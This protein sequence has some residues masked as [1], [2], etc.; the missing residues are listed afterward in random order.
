MTRAIGEEGT[1]KIL[2]KLANLEDILYEIVNTQRLM[3]GRLDRIEGGEVGLSMNLHTSTALKKPSSVA[4]AASK[5]GSAKSASSLKKED[6][7][8]YTLGSYQYEYS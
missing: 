1:E 5:A 3:N 8:A 7:D 4:S 2:D 6:D